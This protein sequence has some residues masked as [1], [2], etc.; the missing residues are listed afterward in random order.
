MKASLDFLYL[1]FGS[2]LISTSSFLQLQTMERGVAA[3]KAVL[4]SKFC[5]RLHMHRNFLQSETLLPHFLD[6]PQYS[7]A[8]YNANKPYIV[9]YATLHSYT[10]NCLHQWY[11]KPELLGW[12]N[13][14]PRKV[15]H[16]GYFYA[17]CFLT[18]VHACMS[19]VCDSKIIHFLSFQPVF[20]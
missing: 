17:M 10:E 1:P 15:M 16:Q 19:S 18:R 14:L 13:V 20:L 12:K 4:I 6:P 5:A 11:Y 3:W 7:Q 9:M 2:L 8:E